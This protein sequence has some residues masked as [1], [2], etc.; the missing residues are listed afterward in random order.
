M[1]SVLENSEKDFIP[2]EKEIELLELYVKLEHFRF[3]DKFEYAITIDENLNVNEFVI[4]PML[5]QP[6]VENA[7]WHGLRYKKEKGKLEINFQEIDS[8]TVLITITDDGIGRKKSQELKT[9][10]QKKQNSKGMGNIQK[11]IAIL[12]QMYKDKVDVEV[13]NIFQ[14]EEG[15]QVQLILKKD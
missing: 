11:R 2:L 14:N 6:Y 12:N 15:T 3:K 9:E 13:N 7:V 5:L 10:N 1:R 4:P 8:E